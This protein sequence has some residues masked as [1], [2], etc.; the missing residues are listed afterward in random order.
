MEDEDGYMVLDKRGAAG[1][2]GPLQDAVSW[3]VLERERPQGT[4]GCKIT[5]L[6]GG[7]TSLELRKNLCP[8]QVD[9]GCK[10]C[11]MGWTLRGTKCY[12]ISEGIELWNKSERDCGN[13]GAELL[14]PGDQDELDFLNEI[15]HKPTRYFW[16]GLSVPSA[17]QGGTWLN[18]SRLDQSR[19]QLSPRAEGCGVL[20]ANSIDAGN[21]SLG[22]QWI[23]QKNATK[24]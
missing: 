3:L 15:L 14:M 1:S 9:K 16:I 13:R 19:F 4:V 21:C 24:L 7:C 8:L 12:W 20:R 11:P 22:F 17:G 23:C 5:S 2:P 18:G 6:G 10:L